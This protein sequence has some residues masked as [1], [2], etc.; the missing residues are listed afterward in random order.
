MAKAIR[1]TNPNVFSVPDVIDIFKRALENFEMF[2]GDFEEALPELQIMVSKPEV[3]VMLGVEDGKFKGIGIV[4]LPDDKFSPIPQVPLFYNEG[5][6]AIKRAL[7][8][9]IVDF[10]VENGYTKFQAINTS[11]KADSIWARAFR[12]A[13]KSRRI[14]SIMEFEIG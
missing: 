14:G 10:I 6:M 12:R 9:K 7:V 3:G 5:S 11:G 2:N 4:L 8:S 13:G 1:L